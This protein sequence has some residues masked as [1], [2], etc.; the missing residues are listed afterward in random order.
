MRMRKKNKKNCFIRAIR[1]LTGQ[2]RSNK[3]DLVQKAFFPKNWRT[4][5]G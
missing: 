4:T 1:V 5:K 2:K 3:E